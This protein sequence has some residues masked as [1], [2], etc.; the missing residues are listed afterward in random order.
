[1]AKTTKTTTKAAKPA[2]APKADKADPAPK[3][4]APAKAPATLRN[5]ADPS[6]QIFVGQSG[7]P[8]YLTLAL[9]NRHGLATCLLYTSDA[10]DE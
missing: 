9:A 3:A 8:E 5:D 1:M 4:A 7:K 6:G 2:K 10:A